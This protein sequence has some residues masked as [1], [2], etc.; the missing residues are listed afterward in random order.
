MLMNEPSLLDP[1]ETIELLETLVR[2]ARTQAHGK[3]DEYAAGLEE[4]R[5][6][7]PTLDSTYL[8]R[9]MLGLVG[10]PLRAKMAKEATSPSGFQAW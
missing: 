4:D 3:A 2:L 5:T 6:R 10:D 9:L 8:Q 1:F 7:Q